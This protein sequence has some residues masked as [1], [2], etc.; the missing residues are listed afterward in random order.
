M[1]AGAKKHDE[2]NHGIFLII[3]VIVFLLPWFIMVPL[4]YKIPKGMA[5]KVYYYSLI[6]TPKVPA[7]WL[8]LIFGLIATISFSIGIK[9]VLSGAKLKLSRFKSFCPLGKSS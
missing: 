8:S 2:R 1:A 9:S 4:L 6:A 5:L 7:L 3:S